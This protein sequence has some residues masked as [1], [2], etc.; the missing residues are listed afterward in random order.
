MLLLFQVSYSA[1][2]DW[3]SPKGTLVRFMDSGKV[4]T[5]GTSIK[6]SQLIPGT[7]YLFR[8][9]ANTERGRGAEIDFVSQ[10][11]RPQSDK[12]RPPESI[13]GMQIIRME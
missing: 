13:L 2:V 7:S 4:T 11:E 12:G 6:I 10:T 8:V 9:S 1:Q 5:T 3:R